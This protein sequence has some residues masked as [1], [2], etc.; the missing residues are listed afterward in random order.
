M[1]EALTI[2][3]DQADDMTHI[4]HLEDGSHPPYPPL[5]PVD[6]VPPRRGLPLLVGPEQTFV[7][8]DDDDIHYRI[9][10][11]LIPST[12]VDMKQGLPKELGLNINIK[13]SEL[14]GKSGN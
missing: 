8:S 14:V 2:G 3:S 1:G 7:K 9:G 11:I 5:K 4:V 13:Y 10:F 6:E 12:E